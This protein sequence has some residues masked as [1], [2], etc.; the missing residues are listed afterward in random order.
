MT[1]A[2]VGEINFSP[3]LTS[4]EACS[5]PSRNRLFENVSRAAELTQ[6]ARCLFRDDMGFAS[7]RRGL[8]AGFVRSTGGSA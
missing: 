7:Y 6:G 4:I 5:A 1:V 3:S 8:A 2:P